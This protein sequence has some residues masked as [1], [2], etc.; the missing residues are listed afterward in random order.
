MATCIT[1]LANITPR[2]AVTQLNLL[3]SSTPNSSKLHKC[4]SK[5]SDITLSSTFFSGSIR[6]LHPVAPLFQ[7]RN[8]LF[9]VRAA[10]EE[11]QVQS[12]VTNKVY[13]DISIGNPQGKFVGRIEIGLFGDDVPQT[14]ENFRALC[15]GEKGFGYKGS[16]FHRV[17]KDFMIQGGD[18]DKGN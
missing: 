13:F 6:V 8:A 15:T 12:K 18:F 11:V 3:S 5:S 4:P 16:S 14:A 9:S 10:A 7:N 17:I 1:S 2:V